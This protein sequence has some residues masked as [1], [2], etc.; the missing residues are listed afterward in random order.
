MSLPSVNPTQTKAWKALEA[1]YKEVKPLHIRTLFSEDEKRAER[2]S[3]SWEDILV[4]YSKNR[5]IPDTI[6]LLI[7]LAKEVRLEDAISGY[8]K[9]GKIN[10][11]EG[12]AVLHTA[13]RTSKKDI[14]L[15][16]VNLIEVIQQVKNKIQ[17]F[18]NAVI[19]GV[20][21]GCTNKS[22]T[23]IVNIGVG[24]SDL[25][26]E[27]V[28]NALKYYKNHLNCHFINNVDGDHVNEIIKKLNPETTLFIVV[29]KSFTTQETI[30]NAL[31]VKEW[32]LSH[33]FESSAIA[34]HFV[35][36][37]ANLDAVKDFGIDENNV[38]AM[39]DWV[40]GR[41]SLWSAVGLSISLAVGYDKF[42]ELLEGANQ[43]DI[44]FETTPFEDNIP[45]ILALLSVWYNNFFKAES[46]AI[47]PYTQYLSKLPAYLQQAV[48]ESN[49]KRVDRNGTPIDYQTGNIIWGQ[50]GT[51]GQHAF[52]QLIHQGTKLIPTDF[53]AFQES[54][55]ENK[56]HH[57]KLIA[58]CIAQ[59]EALMLGKTEEQAIRELKQKG[60]SDSEL[61]NI[62]PYKV[63][64]GNKPTNSIFIKR[65]TPKSLGKLIA[66]YEHKLFV[67]GIIWNIYS[68]D[69]FGVEY[70][71]EL[72]KTIL[73]DFNTSQ[74]SRHDTSTSALI[75][76]YT[77]T[78]LKG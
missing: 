7:D 33:G 69:Q 5:I 30:T 16:G 70:G 49:G 26:P 73:N 51:N 22:F 65:L 12:R 72:A 32:F 23:D 41:F 60:Y 52:F 38:F 9:G 40:G 28:V 55:Y 50:T 35:A 10:E 48:M 71:K 25:G 44:H 14:Q 18:S 29:S 4:D 24:G 6:K 3:I 37:S 61:K 20:Q 68:F 58:N 36:V 63:F 76:T 45:V 59:T 43:M 54:L 75:T 39:W 74:V 34:K 21:K 77:K 1:H 78:L 17:T 62:S 56:N 8:F 19:S 2:F 47:I 66:M 64:E 57:D 11:T 53:I 13:L 42:E 15:E 27:M 46:E 31:T 67:Q